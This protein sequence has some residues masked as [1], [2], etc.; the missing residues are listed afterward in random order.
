MKAIND[1][2]R[3]IYDNSVYKNDVYLH[4][5]RKRGKEKEKE[6]NPDLNLNCYS[7]LTRTRGINNHL[8]ANNSADYLTNET[9]RLRARYDLVNEC[10]CV[11]PNV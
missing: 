9:Q 3:T 10:K 8:L 1:K 4:R 7:C 11:K 2:K 6:I 5:E